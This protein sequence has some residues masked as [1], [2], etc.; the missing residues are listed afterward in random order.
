MLETGHLATAAVP[1]S[2]CWL[3]AAQRWLT[4]GYKIAG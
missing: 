1:G 3:Y 2:F 4:E